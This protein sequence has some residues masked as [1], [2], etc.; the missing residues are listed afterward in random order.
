MPHL[1]N[2]A[3]ELRKCCNHPYLIPAVVEKEVGDHY[4]ISQMIA[5]SGK[6]VLLDK[7]LPK[8]K[9]E[10]HRV[11]VFSQMTKMLDFLE[12]QRSYHKLSN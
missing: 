7:L 11:L 6:M 9:A 8:L 5:S 4:D 12:V 2:V 3:M 10:N 1:V